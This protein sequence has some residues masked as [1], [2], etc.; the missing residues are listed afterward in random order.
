LICEEG[1]FTRQRRATGHLV[2]VSTKLPSEME[3]KP[4][5]R[6]RGKKKR[7]NRTPSIFAGSSLFIQKESF[8]GEF[9]AVVVIQ[10]A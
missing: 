9:A 6:S 8:A 5:L 3:T 4:H 1:K 10:V 2:T 7:S